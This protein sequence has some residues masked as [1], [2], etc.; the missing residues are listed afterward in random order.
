MKYIKTFEGQLSERQELLS[1]AE[2]YLKDIFLELED[3][4]FR[5]GVYKNNIIGVEKITVSIQKK[6]LTTDRITYNTFKISDIEDA[7]L[8][9]NSYITSIGGLMYNSYAR[10]E[11]WTG[12]RY[13]NIDRNVLPTLLESDHNLT[14]IQISFSL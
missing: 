7:L 5:I 13:E 6:V 14:T 9:A 12:H 4:G 2:D 11:T 3:N 1:E 8:F 10:V